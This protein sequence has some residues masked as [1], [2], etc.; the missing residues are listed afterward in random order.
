M[1][2]NCKTCERCIETKP[3]YDVKVE[4]DEIHQ[5]RVDLSHKLSS[6]IAM[7][8][9]LQSDLKT[10]KDMAEDLADNLSKL[11]E[12]VEIQGGFS[13]YKG[14]Q[15]FPLM[16][17]EKSLNKFKTFK[18]ERRDELVETIQDLDQKLFLLESDLKAKADKLAEA[19]ETYC[20]IEFK[21]VHYM[22]EALEEYR[23]DDEITP[24]DLI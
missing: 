20:K 11:K 16:Y 8:K 4:R 3:I 18:K 19:V 9:Q 22:R 17:A 2:N 24:E 21:P 7:N 10:W 6:Y 1:G 14:G 23:G 13:E 5:H 15:P 12:R